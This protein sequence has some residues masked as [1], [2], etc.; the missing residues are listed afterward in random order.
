MPDSLAKSEC[1][2]ER[3]SHLPLAEASTTTL[4]HDSEEQSLPQGG[5]CRRDRHN[6]TYYVNRETHTTT[7]DRPS[8]KSQD[9]ASSPELPLPG[10]WEMRF[11]HKNRKYYLDHNTRITTWNRPSPLDSDLMPLP[12]GWETRSTTDGA[13]TYFIDHNTMTTT[14]E[15]PRLTHA[16]QTDPFSRFQRKIHYLHT[17]MQPLVQQGVFSIKVRRSHIVEDSFAALADLPAND[18]RQSPKVAFEGEAGALNVVRQVFFDFTR[19]RYYNSEWLDVLFEKLFDSSFGLFESDSAG[20][21]KIHPSSATKRDNL[22]YF[23]FVGRLHSLAI[24]HGHLVDPRLVHLFYPMVTLRMDKT[25]GADFI[26]L[27]LKQSLVHITKYPNGGA[28]PILQTN[29]SILDRRSGK[30]FRLQLKA[31]VGGTRSNFLN[32]EDKAEFMQAITAHRSA[33]GAGAQLRAF[34]TGFWEL[35]VKKDSF[36]AYDQWEVEKF[37]GG[38]SEIDIDRSSKLT[39]EESSEQG[40]TEQLKWFWDIVRSWTL[41]RQRLL[42]QYITGLRR[43]PATDQFK[44]LIASDGHIRRLTALGN[45]ERKV[46]DNRDD[47]PE[48]ILFVPAFEDCRTMED[49]LISVITECDVDWDDAALIS[50]FE[51][52]SMA[53]YQVPDNSNTT[54]K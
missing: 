21:L 6:K 14:W 33:G 51:D 50:P 12:N 5:E 37:V 3:G 43:V 23:K 38:V 45:K 25:R 28:H 46:P 30:P 47:S 29:D 32:Y 1:Q 13:S 54:R 39:D 19:Q 42:L 9:R 40:Q 10:G 31:V 16:H 20:T 27:A 24:L 34:M 41:D 4:F 11:D 22:K 52:L 8:I 2:T 44:V 15:D 26:D 49:Q 53:Q 17:L 48:H 18:L 36:L 7:W 35:P